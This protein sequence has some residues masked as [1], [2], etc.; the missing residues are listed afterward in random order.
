MGSSA[1]YLIAK[2]RPAGIGL[3]QPQLYAIG[4][5]RIRAL[6]G[7]E[8][9]DHN[10]HDPGITMLELLAYALTDLTHRASMPVEDIL[11]NSSFFTA[12]TI[13]P[14]HALTVL[15]YRKLIVDVDGVKN[16]WLEAVELPYFADTTT[17]EILLQQPN[18]PNIRQIALKGLWRVRVEYV[19]KA[20]QAAVNTAVMAQ[21]QQHRNLAEDFIEVTGVR[22][23][24]FVLCAEID[25]APAAEV[26]VVHAAIMQQVQEYLAPAV[27]WYSLDQMLER[28]KTVPEIF[29]GPKLRSGFIDTD[30]L[31]ASDLRTEI[32]LSD[33]I[34]IVMDI[35]GVVAVREML[36]APKGLRGPLENRWVVPIDAGKAATLDP[37][38]SRLVYYKRHMPFV[39]AARAEQTQKPVKPGVKDVP[40]PVAAARDFKTYYPVQHHFPALY[41]IGDHPPAATGDPAVDKRRR[42]LA[43]QLKGF[44]LFFDQIMANYCAQ[45]SEIAQLFSTNAAAKATYFQQVVTDLPGYQAIYGGADT[46]SDEKIADRLPPIEEEASRSRRRRR[47]LD[48]LIARCAERFHE[49]A[50]IM[51]SAFGTT[52]AGLEADRCAFLTDYPTIGAN[53]SRGWNHTSTGANDRWNSPNVSGLEDRV[54]RLLG[55][56]NNTRRDLTTVPIAA[57]A[58]IAKDAVTNRFG[59]TLVDRNSPI[60]PKPVLLKDDAEHA[61]AEIA[62]AEM[63]RAVEAGQLPSAYVAGEAGN[64]HI[65]TIVASN[66]EVLGTSREFA[67]AVERDAGMIELSNYLRRHYSREGLY[68]IENILLR[69]LKP[70]DASFHYCV[71]DDCVNCV[72]DPYSY[73]IHVV[74]PAYAGRFND[75]HFRRFV[76]DVIREETPAHILPKIC[77][78]SEADMA[79]FQ[80]AYREWLDARAAGDGSAALKT[81]VERLATVKNVYPR[82]KLAPCDAKDKDKF[83]LG[84]AALGTKDN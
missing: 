27:R 2:S 70:G 77:W 4:L 15:D 78:I 61:T 52:D 51:R 11:K 25:V 55:I 65:F 57:D 49:Y 47:F 81:L 10:V 46:D 35:P 63:L 41:G 71:D 84:R 50:S 79:T 67:T 7:A 12:G 23:Q 83:I 20:D 8:W 62:R 36:I 29:E 31:A 30:E 28:R 21:L 38:V 45:L 17:G 9:T 59:Y 75:M 14:N 33:I 1:A 72:D 43:A 64:K 76:E 74:L 6:A 42:G 37:K 80:T 66:G 3:D 16:A 60:D 68:V 54:A 69:P 82:Q 26:D 13:L 48:H 44:L 56:G 40:L 32:R 39:V 73:R 53:R 19:D 5:D 58:T 22:R 24:S 18:R 34:S